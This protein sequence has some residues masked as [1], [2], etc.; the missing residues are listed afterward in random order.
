MKIL[1]ADPA[2]NITVFVL[3]AVEDPGER[4][5]L[6]RAILAERS[7]GAEQ[8]GFVIPPESSVTGYGLW[9]LEMAGG[10][11]CGN[12]ARSFGLYVARQQGRRGKVNLLVSVSGTGEPVRV[13]ADTERSRASAEMP[14]PAAGAVLD[15]RGL[16]LPVLLFEGITHII[17]PDLEAGRETFFAIKALAEKKFA[18]LPAI[19]VMFYDT[20]MRFMRPAVYVRSVDSM[21]FESSCGSGAAAMGV[22]LSREQQNGIVRYNIAQPGG[23]IETE[24]TKKR[25]KISCITIGG[26]VKMGEIREFAW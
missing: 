23:V 14:K 24:V 7:L 6:A 3:D 10:E 4:T 15:Y 11:F 13:E 21:V 1:V 2:K 18:A 5:A 12:A 16:S 26:E 25:G 17:A 19:G 22:W 8:A 20:T 9:R